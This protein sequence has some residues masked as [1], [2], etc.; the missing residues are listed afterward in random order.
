M[1]PEKKNSMDLGM[2]LGKK[3]NVIA[4]TNNVPS[5]SMPLKMLLLS[6]RTGGV[7]MLAR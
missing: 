4:Q 1:L 7:Q 6:S 3:G 5:K 2:G